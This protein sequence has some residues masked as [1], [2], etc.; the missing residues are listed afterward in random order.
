MI[1]LV[2][3]C[4]RSRGAADDVCTEADLPTCA[5]NPESAFPWLFKRTI[6]YKLRRLP[7]LALLP[8]SHASGRVA[9]AAVAAS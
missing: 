7:D 4:G 6:V 1:F 8:P 5:V 2:G 3:A 9:S